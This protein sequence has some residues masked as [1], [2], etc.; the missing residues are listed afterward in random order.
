MKKSSLLLLVTLLGAHQVYAGV[1]TPNDELENK[2]V[3]FYGSLD[4]TLALRK[5]AVSF[6][7]KIRADEK[8]GIETQ[9]SAIELQTVHKTMNK[10]IDNRSQ[11]LVHVE[12]VKYLGSSHTDLALTDSATTVTESWT[13]LFYYPFHATTYDIKIN[14]DDEEGKRLIF[15]ME[16]GLASA[17]ALYDNYL[18]AIRPY[19]DDSGL[20]RTINDDNIK[21]KNAVEKITNNFKSSRN[22]R[23]ISRV[24][25][26]YKK[27]LLAQD[28]K[29]YPVIAKD[30]TQ[31]FLKGVIEGSY[32]YQKIKEVGLMDRISFRIR[33]AVNFVRDILFSTKVEVIDQ[34]SKGF[35]NSVGLIQ[36]RSG[37]MK[38]LSTAEKLS[39][40]GSMKSLDIVLEKTPFR[41]TDKFI[42]G[43]FGHVAIW[44]GNKQELEE[45]G[46]WS[47]LPF[48][49]KQIR[50]FNDYKGP[51]L[52]EM[53]KSGHMMVEALRP[54][55]QINTL[56]HFINIDDIAV[57]RSNFYMSKESKAEMLLRSF[58]QIGKDYDFNFDVGT[59]KKIVC[60]ELAY[61]VYN[62]IEWNLDKA[63]G[64][65][66]ISPDHVAVEA[67]KVDG[68]FK[69]VMIYYDGKK[70]ENDLI[71]NMARLLEGD[72]DNVTH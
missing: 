13:A 61:V 35:G 38:K 18:I 52:Q 36:T 23:K 9:L 6:Y 43:H 25:K 29:R 45:I 48:L 41:L 27:F 8:A 63:L 71:D 21:Q 20:R 68:L 24:L 44:V 58:M 55:V 31:E 49:T 66:T 28:L 64:R 50:K 30:K 17:L 59:D 70:I 11:L 60:S 37:K 46:V 15:N 3:H 54:G 14:P 47:K 22:F 7:D 67:S 10:Y 32:T 40:Q 51:S 57:L 19:Q 1:Q 12:D 39:I 34:I 26:F 42:P 69:P 72:Y 65:Y 2:L 4:Q 53:V 16:I 5:K 56:E 33:F 62:D